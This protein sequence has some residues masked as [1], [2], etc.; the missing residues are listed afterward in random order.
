MKFRWGSRRSGGCCGCLVFL[1]TTGLIV[2]ITFFVFSRIK[3]S[4]VYQEALAVAQTSEASVQALGEPVE[5]GWWITGSVETS[6][7]S[8]FAD[9]A[10]PVSGPDG[11]GTLYVVAVKSAGLWELQRV[12]LDV[13]G[14]ER[15]PLLTGR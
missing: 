8:G 15:V 2:G 7:T 3:E 1:L 14:G 12:D 9:F 10:F 6:G 13:E 4:D 5:A 11:S